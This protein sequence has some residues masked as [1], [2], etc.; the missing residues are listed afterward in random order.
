V[1]LGGY[2]RLAGLTQQQL[3]ALAGMSVAAVRDLE[4]GR[5]HRPRPGS[6]GRLA[7]ALGLDAVQA[8]TLVLAAQAPAGAPAGHTGRRVPHPARPAD[9]VW[10]QVLGPLAV[11]RHGVAVE[12]GGPKQRAVLGLLALQPGRPVHRGT[13]IDA[14]WDV[15]PPAS[16]INLVQAYVSRLRRLLDPGRAHG[17]GGLLATV[18]GGYRLAVTDDQLDL[19]RFRQL[20]GWAR[21]ARDTGEF[22]TAWALY[23][24]ALGLWQGQP[25]AEVELLGGH[26]GL[27]G[28]AGEHTAVLTESAELGI[29]AGHSE[30]VVGDLQPL[31]QQEPLNEHVHALLLVALAASGQQAAALQVF[32]ELR[33]R[34]DD[35]LGVSPG[36]ELAAAH[37]RVLRQQLPSPVPAGQAGPSAGPAVV[38]R[39]LPAAVQ[40]FAGRARELAALTALA[41]LL[42]PTRPGR[43]GGAGGAVVIS[44][45]GGTAGIGKT[46][47]AVQ[48]A[49]QV[50][51]RFPDGQLYVNLRGFDPA[52]PVSSDQALR[53]FLAALGVAPERIPAELDAQAGL[54]RS[55]LAGRRVLVV[56]DN[57]RDE[58]QVRPLL[59]ASPSCLVLV[60]SRQ[61]LTGLVIREGAH[62]LRLDLLDEAD[63]WALL[64]RRIGSERLAAEPQAAAQLITGCARLPLA[65]AI[66]AARAAAYPHFPLARL[67]AELRGADGSGRLDA[68]DTGEA[69]SSVRA[70]LSWSY[71]NLPDQA[72]RLFRLLGLHPG[73]DIT[74]HA[75]ASLAGVAPGRA[76]QLLR[77]LARAHLLAEPVPGRY[78]FHDLLRAYAAELAHAHDPDDQPCEALTRLF[79]HYLAGAAAA[80]DALVPAE[81]QRRPRIPPPATPLPPL[82]SP[83]AAR[84][85]L[86]DERACL[87]AVA[88]HT[89]AH[90][91][92]EHTTRLATIL[93]RYL[94]RGGHYGDALEIHTQALHAAR[95][96]GDHAAEAYA[97]SSLGGVDW[98]QGRYRQ[99]A[100]HLQQALAIFREL[101]DRFGHARTLSNLGS[102]LWRQGRYQQAADC[103]Q[104]ALTVFQ[105]LGDRSGQA[106]AFGNL[107]NDY[108]RQ[109]R[110]QEAAG[111]YQQALAR[112]LELDDRDG[113]ARALDNLGSLLWRQGRYRQAA[114]HHQHALALCREI[115]EHDGEAEAL[116]R[117]GLVDQHLGRHRQAADRHRQALVLARELG[118]SGREAE[119]LDHLG[120]VDQ[121]LGRHRQALERHRQALATFRELGDRAGQAEACNGVG[122][123]LHAAGR[124]EQARAAHSEALALAGQIGDRYEQ[125]RAHHGLGCA[126]QA[127][128]DL[129]QARHHW[130]RALDLYAELGVPGADQVR[131]SL[132]ALETP[133]TSVP[134]LE[135][136][137]HR[138]RQPRP[139]D[140]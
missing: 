51:D 81:R 6:A 90:G 87:V 80:L 8:Q 9:G 110:Y 38:P 34:L 93:F 40:H 36:P 66:V 113:Q 101:G 95:H 116:D 42:D 138:A 13:I 61:Q 3:A 72:A 53:A 118:A 19:L 98:R 131:A 2:R 129:D 71:R 123:A 84:A 69:A 132:R 31:A 16:A 97:L 27:V 39:Q 30:Q 60:T 35:Q 122:E 75:A 140:R 32:Q 20:V 106:R 56:A 82:A 88:A 135:P 127:G 139:D 52:A 50:A 54:Y 124:P 48:W 117:L 136:T 63:A 37:L 15:D 64:A 28:L 46:A 79:D 5:T 17:G 74:A 26:P 24:Q 115:G 104:Q 65:L 4:Q 112:H 133:S 21:T 83:T 25:L 100:D 33:H 137:L 107:G 85:W 41:E 86:D 134:I 102:L 109:G 7:R 77:E 105:E 78:C 1:L 10:V 103:H 47:L 49:H 70:V 44:A 114:D 73:P 59:P 55:L 62:P 67:A 11:W 108:E 91:W 58:W 120:L 126:H 29:R 119:A 99:A 121:H 12:L 23:Q 43:A 111:Y 130:Q 89:A 45:I 57:A 125:A 94:D 14:L 92:P 96:S 18:G 68:L 128:G 22:A 76:D